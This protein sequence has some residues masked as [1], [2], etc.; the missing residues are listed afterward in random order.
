[1]KN[2]NQLVVTYKQTKDKE[3]LNQ[4]FSLLNKTIHDKATYIFYRKK[5]YKN[6]NCFYLFKIKTLQLNDIENELKLLILK[7]IEKTDINKPFDKYL[8]SSIWNWGKSLSSL[9][10]EINYR[11]IF[12]YEDKL[13]VQ[14][15][16]D[17]YNLERLCTTKQEQMI[18]EMIKESPKIK[19]SEM[20]ERLEVTQSRIA[21]ILKKLRKKIRKYIQT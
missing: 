14:P 8:F 17:I 6:K 4:I 19:Q 10:E 15:N 13:T 12:Q 2:L 1:M 18:I 16:I 20:A 9:C 3:I 5:F 11:S 7:L 21:Q